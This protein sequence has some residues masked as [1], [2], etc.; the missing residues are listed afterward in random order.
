MVSSM[1]SSRSVDRNTWYLVWLLAE[2]LT[3]IQLWYL[4]W[5]LVEQLT[6]IHGI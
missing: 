4:V 6:E 3:E 1:A 2:Q 5:L